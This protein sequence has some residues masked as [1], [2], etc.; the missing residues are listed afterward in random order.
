MT[1]EV[2]LPD[3]SIAEFP[4]DMPDEKIQEIIRADLMKSNPTGVQYGQVGPKQSGPI[5]G[6]GVKQVAKGVAR[7]LADPFMELTRLSGQLDPLQGFKNRLY[8][9]L[10]ELTGLPLTAPSFQ[11]SM[12]QGEQEYQSGRPN[13]E[14]LDVSRLV[15]NLLSPPNAMMSFMPGSSPIVKGALSG[16]GVSLLTPTYKGGDMG[17]KLSQVGI[18]TSL[19]A[20]VGSVTAALKRG[21]SPNVPEDIQALRAMGVTPTL[22]QRLGEKASRIEEGLTSAPLLGSA[23]RAARNRTVADFNKGIAS[24]ILSKVNV[25]VPK[26]LQAGHPLVDYVGK[27]LG[28]KYDDLLPQLRGQMDQTFRQDMAKVQ[29]MGLLLPDEQRNQLDRILQT[30]VFDKFTPQGMASGETLKEIEHQLGHFASGHMKSPDFDKRT[31]GEALRE[32]QRILREMIERNNPNQAGQL[33]QINSAWADFLRMERAAV[34]A[35]KHEGVFSPGNFLQAVK[36]LTPGSR[37]SLFARGNARLQ[38]DAALGERVLGDVVRDSG[39]AFRSAL[40]L[41]MLG[42]GYLVHP[43]I[44]LGELAGAVPYLKSGQKGLDLLMS[45]GMGWRQPLGDM[46]G[47]VAGPGGAAVG[48]LSAMSGPG[49]PYLPK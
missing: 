19:G 35:G 4:D 27:S 23:I 36:D 2:E 26:D 39:T 5:T 45:G 49:L 31:L 7:G 17:D 29:T 40:G 12:Q 33:Q 28:D 1:I 11:R 37:K 18:G 43:G 42:G 47:N 9:P 48:A 44:A 8:S 10:E 6:P 41:G 3:G 25:E 21:V 34:K 32:S 46:I 38:D 30:Q 24:K 16:A 13:P 14:D 20:G 15:G 22:G